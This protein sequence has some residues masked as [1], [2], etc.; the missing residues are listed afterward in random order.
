MP[1][2]FMELL[3]IFEINQSRLTRGI[4]FGAKKKKKKGKHNN[5]IQSLI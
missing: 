5:Q 2:S 4:L 1:L 3:L